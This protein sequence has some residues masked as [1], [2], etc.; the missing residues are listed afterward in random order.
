VRHA[1]S[2]DLTMFKVIVTRQDGTYCESMRFA[3]LS[4]ANAWAQWQEKNGRVAH[5]TSIN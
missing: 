1:R 3:S 5:I 4:D 2:D